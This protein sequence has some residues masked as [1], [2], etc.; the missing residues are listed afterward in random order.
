MGNQII[1][2]GASDYK[3]IN[4]KLFK[5]PSSYIIAILSKLDKNLGGWVNIYLS[6]R[7]YVDL[8]NNNKLSFKEFLLN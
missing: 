5:V 3:N 8:R 4:F 7:D 1:F 6:F 2:C